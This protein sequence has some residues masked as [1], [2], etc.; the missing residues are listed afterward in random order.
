M[1]RCPC[2]RRELPGVETL[3]DQCFRAGYD[4]VTHPQPWWHRLR[5]RFARGNFAAFSAIFVQGFL[6]PRPGEPSAFEESLAERERQ[7]R[8]E[9]EEK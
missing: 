4:R 9:R 3:C 8:H 2:C 5:P 7:R 6:K 1:S